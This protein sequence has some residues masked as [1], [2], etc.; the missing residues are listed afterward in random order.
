[1]PIF[2]VVDKRLSADSFFLGEKAQNFEHL[3]TPFAD[4]KNSTFG[5]R[6]AEI[7]KPLLF[8]QVVSERQVQACRSD[9]FA[10]RAPRLNGPAPFAAST[11]NA[12]VIDRSLSK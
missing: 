11:R 5:D 4:C 2:V 1:M 7:D 12:P 9:W 6:I 3:G 10:R 8:E